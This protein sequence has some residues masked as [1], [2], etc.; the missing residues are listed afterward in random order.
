M[1]CQMSLVVAVVVS[2][3][4]AS[5]ALAGYRY[6][7]G[8]EKTQTTVIGRV[9]ERGALSS[10]GRLIGYVDSRG[11]LVSN[12][13]QSNDVG[14][15][16]D[17]SVRNVKGLS[18]T[19]L[20]TVLNSEVYNNADRSFEESCKVADGVG[21]EIQEIW[22]Q[23]RNGYLRHERVDDGNGTSSEVGADNNKISQI[24]KNGGKLLAL[25]HN[26]PVGEQK[27]NCGAWPSKMD[28][29]NLAVIDQYIVDCAL[30]AQRKVIH[31]S[32]DDGK[33]YS[34]GSNGSEEEWTFEEYKEEYGE[35]PVANGSFICPVEGD[36]GHT[37][38]VPKADGKSK[39]DSVKQESKDSASV[40]GEFVGGV[41]NVASTETTG[42]IGIKGWCRC[43]EDPEVRGARSIMVG[44]GDDG[45]GGIEDPTRPLPKYK[46]SYRFCL[47]C[48]KC[49]RPNLKW[50][51]SSS[52]R[53]FDNQLEIQL[54]MTNGLKTSEYVNAR[55]DVERKFI[56]IPDG[57]IVFPGKCSCKEP[58]PIRDGFMNNYVCVV[59]GKCYVPVNNAVPIGPTAREEMKLK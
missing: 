5:E 46:Y 7:A 2:V 59:C 38:Y 6:K 50:D 15:G 58:D 45:F 54:A 13:K 14:A 3:I 28:A 22:Y 37:A 25:V 51:D 35:R 40:K 1:K 16:V 9:V 12:N 29:N 52:R 41:T 43:W 34:V 47:R 11:Q 53:I 49:R 20:R 18:K 23:D 55:K 4:V 8:A 57:Q 44:G 48:G 21:K 30:D 56:N 19:E 17:A 27:M 39:S 10:G 36:G 33:I 42:K 26:H 32:K 31:F 24:T